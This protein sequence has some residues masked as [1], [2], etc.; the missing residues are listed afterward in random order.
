MTDEG[1]ES[2]SLH[3]AK[4]NSILFVVRSGILRRTFP[5][6]MNLIPTTVN[7]DLKILE[8]ISPKIIPEYILFYFITN[9]NKLRQELSKDGTTVESI[10]FGRLQR[11]EIP[12]PDIQK[13]KQIVD[14]AKKH[15]SIIMTVQTM[16]NKQVNLGNNL[17]QSIL[18]RAFEGE[19]L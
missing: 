4:E 11:L 17:R 9:N 2:K 3:L 6:T 7:Q 8:I 18:K 16:L 5:V 13:Q 15:L 10:D 12:L 14:E 1:Y 19:L